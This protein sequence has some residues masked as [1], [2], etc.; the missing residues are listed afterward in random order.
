MSEDVLKKVLM[1]SLLV[2]GVIDALYLLFAIVYFALV[3]AHVVI[4]LPFFTYISIAIIG[5]NL[6]ECLYIPIYLKFRK[7]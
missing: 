7:D 4:I 1:I 5:I 2:V 6:I 3:L